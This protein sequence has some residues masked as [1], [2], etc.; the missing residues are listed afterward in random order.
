MSDN[1][2]ISEGNGV[3]SY[4]RARAIMGTRFFGFEEV[5]K[6]Y[7]VKYS[8]DDRKK[9]AEIPFDEAVLHDAY[10]LVPGFWMSINNIRNN[11]NVR[12]GGAL[13][14]FFSV[15]LRCPQY[16]NQLFANTG[17]SVRWFLFH[18]ARMECSDNER[19]M[20]NNEEPWRRELVFA[21]ITSYLITGEPLFENI[22]VGCQDEGREGFRVYGN[23]CHQYITDMGHYG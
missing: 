1:K 10:A 18:K 6:A 5:E 22:D 13:Q 15:I 23:K 3:T 7:D 16:N 12:K 17:V 11:Q 19:V 9:L 20:C 8:I 4:E 2:S 21:T 14:L